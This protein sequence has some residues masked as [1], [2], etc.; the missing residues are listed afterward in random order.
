[1]AARPIDPESPVPLYHQIAESIRAR[2]VAGELV[3]GDVLEPL[4]E[5]ARTWG[6]NLHTVRHAYTALAREGLVEARGHRGTRVAAGAK[7]KPAPRADLGAF[8]A[9]TLE[10]ARTRHGL[11]AATLAAA[12]LERGESTGGERPVVHV[13]EC[14]RYQCEV[15]A[16]ELSA[17]FAVDARAWSLEEEAEP[18][19]GPIVAT[20]FHNNDLRRR[21]PQRLG[22]IRFVTIEPDPEIAQRIPD[23]VRRVLV[24]E[25]D[26]VTA[27][28]VAADLSTALTAAGLACEVVVVADVESVIEQAAANEIVVAS[29]RVWGALSEATRTCGRVL[30]ARYFIDEG[31]LETIGAELS[32]R[33]ASWSPTKTTTVE[34]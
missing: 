31:D 1:M 19:A 22:E 20:Y 17:R 7:A 21:W 5:A 24:C 28:S 33:P 15:H 9:R 34:E 2:I 27:E 8:L 30:E 6:V 10:E 23:G 12:I 13:V 18:P 26:A 32:W 3:P 14:S 25:R 29:P 4:R 11:D 16:R